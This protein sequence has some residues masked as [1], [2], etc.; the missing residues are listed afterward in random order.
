MAANREKED[1]YK[2]LGVNNDASAE[3]VKKAYRRLALKHHPDKNPGDKAS[4]ERFKEISEAYEVISDPVKRQQ[5][6]QFGHQAFAPGGGMRGG[7]AHGIDLEEAL[8]T[9]MGAMGGG[10]SIFEDVFETMGGHGGRGARATSNR[11]ADLRF[12]LEIDF[13]EAVLGS[14]RDISFPNYEPCTACQGSGVT[15]GSKKEKCSRC[16]GMGAVETSAGF[17]RVRQTC[18]SCNGAGEIIRNPCI[19][20][21]GAG[22]VKSRTSINLKI[23]AGV[24]TGSRLRVASKG[25]CGSNGGPA[26]DLYV[27]LHVHAHEIFKRDGEDIFCDVPVPFHIFAAGGEIDVPTIHGYAKLKIPAGTKNGEIFRLRGKGVG[28]GK[29]F[30]GGDQHVRVSVEVPHSLSSEQ[31]KII[32][33]WEASLKEDNHPEKKAFYAKAEEF[34]ERKKTM[35]EKSTT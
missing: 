27:I 23:P 18:P 6:D 12:D 9:F 3:E 2:T 15:P 10:G 25:E 14:N 30:H 31:K 16:G 34:F 29:M 24:E 35:E 26:G 32:Q 20:C 11:G 13:E 7:F 19:K 33:N 21:H 28:G 4:E 17:F 1:Y 22:K 5:Y 8:R